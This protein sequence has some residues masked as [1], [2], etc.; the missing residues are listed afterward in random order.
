MEGME[1]VALRALAEDALDA[2]DLRRGE[3]EVVRK[4]RRSRDKRLTDLVKQLLTA[5]Q[6]EARCKAIE[7]L[8]EL[9]HRGALPGASRAYEGDATFDVREDAAYAMARLGDTEMVDAF[10]KLVRSRQELRFARRWRSRSGR[11][12]SSATCGGCRSCSR[13]TRRGITCRWWPT[14]SGSTARRRWTLAGSN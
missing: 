1:D 8:V 6:K 14:R 2:L 10:L 4:R 3:K 12:G 13:P 7:G 5:S 9:G 11:S